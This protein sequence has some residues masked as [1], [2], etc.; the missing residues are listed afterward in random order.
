ME[1][2]GGLGNGGGL[3]SAGGGNGGGLGTPSRGGE[4]GGLGVG[5]GDGEFGGGGEYPSGPPHPS[6][7]LLN[8]H[9]CKNVFTHIPLGV[10]FTNSPIVIPPVMHSIG[11]VHFDDAAQAASSVL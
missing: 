8:V 4:G 2:G 10:N 1:V 3:G 6:H 11:V 7:C 9:S 5:G